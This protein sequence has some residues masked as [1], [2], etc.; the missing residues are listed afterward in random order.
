MNL[1]IKKLLNTNKKIGIFLFIFFSFNFLIVFWNNIWIP[2]IVIEIQSGLEKI[3]DFKY[4]CKKEYCKINLNIEKIF[5]WSYNKNSYNCEWDF[6]YWTYK[7]ENTD[8]KCNPWYINYWTWKFDLSVKVLEKNDLN[9]FKEKE[10]QIIN[11]DEFLEEL[12]NNNTGS[13]IE[14]SIYNYWT[15]NVNQIENKELLKIIWNFQRPSYILNKD[16]K[17]EK[18]FCDKIKEE[19][20]INLDLRNSFIW[21]FKEKDYLCEIDFWLWSWKV[22]WEENKCNPNT[23][24][25]WSWSFNVNFKI[26]DKKNINILSTWSFIVENKIETIKYDIQEDNNNTWWSSNTLEKQI[27]ILKN[28]IIQSWLKLNSEKKYFCDKEICSI[29]LNYENDNSNLLCQWSFWNW[30]FTT[31]NTDKKCNPWYIKYSKWNHKIKLR[32]YDKNYLNNFKEIFLEFENIFWNEANNQLV[33]ENN[34]EKKELKNN[35]NIFDFDKLNSIKLWNISVNPE[36]TDILEYVEI[37]NNSS[38]YIV[39]LKW[40]FLDDT[41]GKGS[42]KYIFKNDYFLFQN[43]KKKIYKSETKINL[44]NTWDEVNLICGDNNID[45][46]KWNFPVKSWYLLNHKNTEIKS[47]KAKVIYVI[48]WDTIILKLLDWTIEKLR[49][50]WIDTPETKDPRKPVQFFGLQASNYTNRELLWKE[51]FLEIDKDNYRDKYSR[52]LWYVKINNED[53]NKKLIRNWYAIVYDKFDFEYLEEYKKAEKY[54]QENK[55][56][57]WKN[58]SI[59]LWEKIFKNKYKKI[60]E[61]DLEYKELEKKL[62]N[63]LEKIQKENELHNK[64]IGLSE[65]IDLL[66]VDKLDN[67]KKAINWIPNDFLEYKEANIFQKNINFNFLKV[68]NNIFENNEYFKNNILKYKFN[69]DEVFILN[70][71]NSIN[72]Y[73]N[74]IN[75]WFKINVSKLKTWLKIYWKTINNSKIILHINQDKYILKSDNNWKFVFKINNLDKIKSWNF[76]I[77]SEIIDGFWNQFNIEKKKKFSVSKNYILDLKLSIFEKQYKDELQTLNYLEKDL[78]SLKKDFNRIIKKDEREKFS[79]LKKEKKLKIKKEKSR[80][81]KLKAYLKKLKKKKK[82]KNKKNKLPW[83]R[84]NKVQIYDKKKEYIKNTENKNWILYYFLIIIF[85]FILIFILFKREKL[86]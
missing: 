80:L 11:G 36:W 62:K 58:L 81:K 46:I 16:K 52:L 21:G 75:W 47:Q 64:Y 54:A 60:I 13:L 2:E 12:E 55:L 66:F 83:E 24:I 71:N 32:I 9:N 49:L 33:K 37:I 4:K 79:K 41:L 7:T 50:I 78:I 76:E 17:L 1:N 43:S 42:K 85:G 70:K 30:I 34:I 26:I 35:N 22:T 59:K 6:W 25:F 72:N 45:K 39:N 61:K 20:K 40:C 29:N 27:I 86:I 8:K 57:M 3:W 69:D 67:D 53:F 74:F 44:N 73:R 5:S 31:E 10:F 63:K 56:G 38:N 15:W 48:D 28:I 51:V 65:E 18:Y 19:C 77:I 23:V 14:Y 68:L 82:L 84:L